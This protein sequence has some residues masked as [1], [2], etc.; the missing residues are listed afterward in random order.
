MVHQLH[1]ANE[2]TT[3][4]LQNPS[5]RYGI[6]AVSLGSTTDLK[7]QSASVGLF[8]QG[9]TFNTRNPRA[10]KNTQSVSTSFTN[11]LT[12]RNRRT[13][14]SFY[15]QIEIEPLNLNIS[16]ESSQNVEVELRANPTFSG[17]TNFTTAG[18]N[19][20]GDIDTTS[21]TTSGGRLLAAFTIGSKGSV[22]VNLKDLEIRIP[23][24]L[25]ISVTARVTGGASSNVTAT[26]TYYEDL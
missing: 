16:S 4:S 17:E 21:N 11:V 18:T 8:V 25:K 13:Y 9:Q 10:V 19:L 22:N 23:P 7:I 3:P 14:N 5:L 26:L 2:G 12:L 6:Y 15:N 1:I 24:S 20:V